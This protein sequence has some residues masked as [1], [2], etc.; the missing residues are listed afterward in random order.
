[1][2]DSPVICDSGGWGQ[3]GALGLLSPGQSVTVGVTT[4]VTGGA[5]VSRSNPLLTPRQLPTLHL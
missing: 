3:W 2:F 5:Q 4:P 1:M